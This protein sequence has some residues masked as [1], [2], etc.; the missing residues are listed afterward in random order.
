MPQPFDFIQGVKL[1]RN[2]EFDPTK[3]YKAIDNFQKVY[4]NALQT[5]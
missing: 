5:D 3:F 1:K 4:Y 2:Y